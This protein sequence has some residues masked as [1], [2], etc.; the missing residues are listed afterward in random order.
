M[1]PVRHQ[2]CLR[3]SPELSAGGVET[4]GS[5][6]GKGERAGVGGPEPEVQRPWPQRGEACKGVAETWGSHTRVLLCPGI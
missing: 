4:E 1:A 2:V 6:Q 5:G 3:R